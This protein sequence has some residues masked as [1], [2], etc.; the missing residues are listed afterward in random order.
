MSDYPRRRRLEPEP[1]KRGGLPI[2]P[3]VVLVIL[4]GLLLGG[5]LTKIFGVNAVQAPTPLPSFTPLPE[6]TATFTAAQTPLP[7]ATK[8]PHAKETPKHEKHASPAA[9]PLSSPS[10]TPSAA[11][12]LTPAA[13]KTPPIIILTPTPAPR[14]TAASAAPSAPPS[15]AP[16]AATATPVLITGANSS[17]HAASIV[18]AYVAALARGDSATAAGYLASGLPTET[19]INPNVTV[20]LSD[21]RA[22]RNPDGSFGVTAQIVTSKGT[23]LA[24]FT[25]R[26][27]TYGMQIT[28][29]AATHL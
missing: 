7:A 17:D 25:L 18:R 26:M 8:S 6:A 27:G 24:S 5:L 4:G 14:V 15:F 13:R 23:Y 12:S 29:H 3:L 21:L 10:V 22:S 1:P 2:V 19:F 11:P 16:A 20:S 28:E 9:S